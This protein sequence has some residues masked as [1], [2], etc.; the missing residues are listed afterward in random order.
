M[1]NVPSMA[2]YK[3]GKKAQEVYEKQAE[4]K[5]PHGPVPPGIYYAQIEP[6]KDYNKP[7]TPEENRLEKGVRCNQKKNG[8]HLN[9]M[10]RLKGVMSN[11]EKEHGTRYAGKCVFANFNIF[12]DD[13]ETE[14][15]GRKGSDSLIIACGLLE[16]PNGFVD[17][18]GRLLTLRLGYEKSNPDENKV[19]GTMAWDGTIDG[20]VVATVE[21]AQK[22]PAQRMPWETP[23]ETPQAVQAAQEDLGFSGGGFS[24]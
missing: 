1:K 13:K 18:E 3:V 6:L 15:K 5:A 20:K 9:V 11:K 16:L 10:F 8:Y 21:V 14:E 4:V 23:P 22:S 19:W 17:L 24:L 7:N 2:G 12:H